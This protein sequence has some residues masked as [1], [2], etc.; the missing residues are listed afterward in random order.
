MAAAENGLCTFCSIFCS[1]RRSLLIF[2]RR[3]WIRTKIDFLI[4][5]LYLTGAGIFLFLLENEVLAAKR[6]IRRGT[7]RIKSLKFRGSIFPRSN[8]R[9]TIKSKWKHFRTFQILSCRMLCDDNTSGSFWGLLF[10]SC[11]IKA[12][13]VVSSLIGGSTSP[14]W[15]KPSLSW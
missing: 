11:F 12:P 13:S 7:C 1:E 5:P 14:G 8:F 10:F 2:K 15:K 6:D 4:R 3:N 9:A